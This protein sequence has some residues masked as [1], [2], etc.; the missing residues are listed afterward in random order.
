MLRIATVLLLFAGCSSRTEEPVILEDSTIIYSAKKE[1]DV[2]ALITLCRKEDKKTG[3]RMG[4]GNAFT[5][6][7]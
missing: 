1:N 7:E 6:M 3:D 5:I 4:E 2:E